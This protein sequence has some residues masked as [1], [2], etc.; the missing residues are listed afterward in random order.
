MDDRAPSC[1]FRVSLGHKP[2]LHGDPSPAIGRGRLCLGRAYRERMCVLRIQLSLARLAKL[3]AKPSSALMAEPLC[4][5][6]AK[7]GQRGRQGRRVG[8]SSPTN[9]PTRNTERRCTNSSNGRSCGHLHADAPEFSPPAPGTL[10][11]PCPG[12]AQESRETT[13]RAQ[14]SRQCPPGRASRAT[15]GT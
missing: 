6:R 7:S 15:T 1:F 10:V 11:P 14:K 4:R 2:A 9:Q 5:K 8:A 12:L 3:R 13:P